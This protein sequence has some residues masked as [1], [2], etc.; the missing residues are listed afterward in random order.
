MTR[1][2]FVH[3][4][5]NIQAPA[6]YELRDI[7]SG[8]VIYRDGKATGALPGKLLRGRTQAPVGMAAE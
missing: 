8:E 7:K 1:E 3:K 2:G 4:A 5:Y 6:D